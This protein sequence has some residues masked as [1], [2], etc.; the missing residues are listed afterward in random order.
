MRSEGSRSTGVTII[1]AEPRQLTVV[2]ILG[3]IDLDRLSGLSGQFGIPKLPKQ[4]RPE[5]VK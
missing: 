3:D 5:P 4:L 1:T 2:Q